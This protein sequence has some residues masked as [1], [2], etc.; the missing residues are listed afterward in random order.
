M[1]KKQGDKSVSSTGTEKK[2]TE[3]KQVDW[4]VR[5]VAG[6]EFQISGVQ[7]RKPRVATEVE[8]RATERRWLFK[9][10]KLPAGV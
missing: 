8:V 10:H 4:T 7:W 3:K 6:K 2:T 9:K 5:R 1:A